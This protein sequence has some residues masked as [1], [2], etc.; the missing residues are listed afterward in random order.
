MTWGGLSLSK[1]LLQSPALPTELSEDK[2]INGVSSSS[3][4]A[5]AAELSE[6]V[7]IRHFLLIATATS[8]A[9]T[10]RRYGLSLKAVGV[11]PPSCRITGANL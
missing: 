11:P 5:G 1:Q 9:E 7:P 6:D 2:P 3:K 10:I 8:M 4:A